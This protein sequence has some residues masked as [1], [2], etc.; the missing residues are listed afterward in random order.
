MLQ[1]SLTITRFELERV[2][3]AVLFYSDQVLVRATA[4]TPPGDDL[5]YRRLNELADLGAVSTWAYEYELANGGRPVRYGNGRLLIDSPARHVVT[6]EASRELVSAVDNELSRDP[7]KPYEGVALREG[8]SEVVQLR[9]SVTTLRMTDHL[10][11]QGIIGGSP[12]QS[13]LINQVQRATAAAD[14]TEAV[15]SEVVS[16]CEF[17]PLSDLPVAAIEDCRR[18]M[19]HFQY[20]LNERLVGQ[21]PG[22][23]LNPGQVAEQ[24]ISEY[25]KINRRQTSRSPVQDSWDVVGMVL[26]HA[27][28]IK[29]M[30]TRIEW[31]KYRG[32]RHR[33]FIL[34]GKIQHH[35]QEASL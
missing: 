20:Y 19:S 23:V 18:E 35:A 27:V 24:I 32:V 10:G 34:L 1:R 11:A 6:T 26:P 9:H 29:A 16:R 28:L 30:G 7:Q 25:R 33:P 31:F 2:M 3:Q 4:V 17:G 8:V 12:G 5:V 21:A 22:P 14:A 15:V 13:S